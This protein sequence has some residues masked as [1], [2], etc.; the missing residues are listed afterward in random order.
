VDREGDSD[1][2]GIGIS[3]PA[4]ARASGVGELALPVLLML[5]V[6]CIDSAVDWSREG[7][8]GLGVPLCLGSGRALLGGRGNDMML[9][10]T[11]SL[12]TLAGL[13]LVGRL[14]GSLTLKLVLL[15][16]AQLSPT[17]LSAAGG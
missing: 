15:G 17:L 13:A 14:G 11:F 8:V 5:S 2:A 3:G 6:L 4:R 10:A 16:H 12:C 9:L 1:L 7:G